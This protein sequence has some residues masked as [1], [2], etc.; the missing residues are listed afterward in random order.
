MTNPMTGRETKLVELGYPLAEVPKAAANYRPLII[1][2]SVGYLS[3]A[4]PFCRGNELAFAGRVPSQITMEDARRAA[5]LCAA[6][7]LR[8]LHAELGTLDRIER[9]LRIAGYV[10]SDTDFT[11]QHLV[12]N[13]ASDLLVEVLGEAGRHARSAVGVAQLPLGA[14]VEVDMVV[15]LTS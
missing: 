4:I 1:D 13:G 2:G 12:L 3:G 14:A 7:L 10:N 8:V 11:E 6:N 15:K 5:A 9:V